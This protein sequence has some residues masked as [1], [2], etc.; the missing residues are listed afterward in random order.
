MAKIW[1]AAVAFVLLA[2]ACSTLYFSVLN[3]QLSYRLKHAEQENGALKAENEAMRGELNSLVQNYSSLEAAYASLNASYADLLQERLALEAKCDAL[4]DAY[5]Q[6]N[7][8]Y[9]QLNLM[10]VILAEVYSALN[11]TYNELLAQYSALNASYI[12]LSNSYAK[13]YS[14]LYEPPANKTVPTIEELKAWLGEDPTDKIAYSWPNFVCGDFAVMLAFHAKLIDWDMGVVGI[15]GKKADG[16]RFDHAFNAIICAEG[17]VYVEP[18]TDEVW[19]Y[20][21]HSE[22]TPGKWYDYPNFGQIYVEQYII[23]LLYE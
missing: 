17:L 1:K 12:I 15:L 22:I 19:W 8:S 5:R 6:L 10:Y 20:E 9:N 2:L 3:I 4:E 16:A 11:A 23:I 13:L 14:A 21:N 18:Q 7:A